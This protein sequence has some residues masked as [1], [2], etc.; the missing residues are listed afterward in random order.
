MVVLLVRELTRNLPALTK[1]KFHGNRIRPN[2]LKA[3]L[4]VTAGR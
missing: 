4:L 3:A 2:E 1:I